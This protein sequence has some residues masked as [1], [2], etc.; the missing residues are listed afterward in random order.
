MRVRIRDYKAPPQEPTPKEPT[1]SGELISGNFTREDVMSGISQLLGMVAE[2][3]K[4][5]GMSAKPESVP[6]P[7]S[8]IDIE[9]GQP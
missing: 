8:D 9:E 6:E 5:A 2:L 1:P 7:A 4:N 3:Q